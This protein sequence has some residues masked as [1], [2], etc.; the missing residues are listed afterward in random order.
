[1]SVYKGRAE[2]VGR[3][4]I[5]ANDPGEVDVRRWRTTFFKILS[6]KLRKIIEPLAPPPEPKR[7]YKKRTPKVDR[8]R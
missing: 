7:A 5:D 4:Q 6:N 1:M 2:V 3:A 8:G